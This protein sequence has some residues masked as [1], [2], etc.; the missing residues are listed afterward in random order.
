MLAVLLGGG[1][2][3][4][5]KEDVRSGLG[6]EGAIVSSKSISDK[7]FLEAAEGASKQVALDLLSNPTT[8]RAASDFLKVVLAD[9][10][11]RKAAGEL[12]VNLYR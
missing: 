5:F 10:V 11:T 9:E 7:R 6:A 8:V 4:L 2:L 3:Y 1:G 12:V